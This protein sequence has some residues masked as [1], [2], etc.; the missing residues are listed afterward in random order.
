MVK[1]NIFI[2]VDTECSI[3]GAFQ[4]PSLK[5]VGDRKRI[6]G[7]FDGKYYG[8]PMIMDIAESYGLKLTFFVEAMNRLY[9][10]DSMTGKVCEDILKRNH[11]IQ[12][13]NHPN[14]QNFSAENNSNK[15]YSDFMKDYDLE[16][17]SFLINESAQYLRSCGVTKLKA[18]RAGSYGADLNTLIAL[19][20]NGLIIDSSY[21]AAYL[22]SFCSI[23]DF[24]IN[25]LLLINNI[26]EFP[27]TN[28]IE[29]SKIR[30]TQLKPLDL[31]GVSFEEIREV[32]QNACRSGPQNITLIIHS[33][34]FLKN[35]DVQY[36]KVR[37]LE[38]VINRFKKL[39]R[40]L[41]EHQNIFNVRTL[42]SLN[43]ETLKGLSER[44][45]HHF[46]SVSP[47]RSILRGVR[48]V[49]DNFI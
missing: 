13:H 42:G 24:S 26:Y 44:S 3:G 38:T 12:L 2:T 17:Q 36:K 47:A 37:V 25:D 20:N 10:G 41:S 1:P 27:I 43:I 9:F 19:K 6:Y 16:K 21:N 11:D 30:R 4:N 48:Q 28:F 23:P 32:I 22:H 31:N 34:S 8:I 39:C 5:P 49:W 7:L 35:Y 14:Y 29:S 15:L 45:I 46:P 40:Y 33:F 18:F